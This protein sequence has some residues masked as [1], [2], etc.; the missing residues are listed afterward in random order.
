MELVFPD[1]KGTGQNFPLRLVQ[2]GLKTNVRRCV[3]GG[4]AIIAA[5]PGSEGGA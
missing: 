5:V 3:L 4:G 1:G 2:L